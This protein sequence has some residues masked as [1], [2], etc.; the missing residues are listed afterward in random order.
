MVRANRFRY[1]IIEHLKERRES[2][3]SQQ[4]CRM[5]EIEMTVELNACDSVRFE[6]EC[7]C[8]WDFSS[9]RRHKLKLMTVSGMAELL[10]AGK[11]IADEQTSAKK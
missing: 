6:V 2:E 4:M 11:N 10:K 9:M 1:N 7:F 5:H 8:I 3:S